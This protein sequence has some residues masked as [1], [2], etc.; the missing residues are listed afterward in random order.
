M[1]L[2]NLKTKVL[3]SKI[4]FVNTQRIFIVAGCSDG[5]VIFFF[6]PNVD[7]TKETQPAQNMESHQT[8]KNAHKGDLKTI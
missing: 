8:Y 3:I 1:S 5:T 6:Y 7:N 2:T 4:H